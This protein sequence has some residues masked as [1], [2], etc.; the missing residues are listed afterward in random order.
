MTVL[1][2]AKAY[3]EREECLFRRAIS[4]STSQKVG[5]S[6]N[7]LLNRMHS[8][9]EFFL[10]GDYNA[11]AVPNLKQDG[12]HFFQFDSEIFDVW[13]FVEDAGTGGTTE[14]DIKVAATPGGSFVSIFTTRPKIQ[15]SAGNDKWIHVGSVVSGT[16]APVLNNAL[17]FPL[18]GSA[19][20][21][22]LIDAQTGKVASCGIVVHYRPV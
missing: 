18:A 20:R 17:R 22:D 3:I 1:A 12:F 8:Q 13:M 9:K 19:I 21:C 6:I 4:E 7:F 11:V 5:K 14:L 10:N 16:V 2:D 15:S